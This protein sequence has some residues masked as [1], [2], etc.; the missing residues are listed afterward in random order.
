M[1]ND[2]LRVTVRR[3]EGYDE[4]KSF[5]IFTYGKYVY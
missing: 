5:E 1:A 3:V 2:E 4:G